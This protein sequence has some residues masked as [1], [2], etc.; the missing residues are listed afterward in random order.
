MKNFKKRFRVLVLPITFVL[1]FAT[2]S[3]CLEFQYQYDIPSMADRETA[4]KIW[5]TVEN[6]KGVID[7]DV[8]LERKYLFVTFDD[9]YVDEEVIQTA[10]E[11]A[12]YKVKRMSLM[13]EPR[14][15]VMN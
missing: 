9:T 12:G 14:E 13:L 10:L 1:L 11:K 4:V 6:I 8:N 5:E 15:G 3:F 2:N 7:I